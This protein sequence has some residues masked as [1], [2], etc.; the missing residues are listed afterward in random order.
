[1]IDDKPVEVYKMVHEGKRSMC[2]IEAVEG[3]E[4]KVQVTKGAYS[5]T[6]YAAYLQLDGV[7]CVGT[8]F[9]SM[10]SEG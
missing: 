7:E 3:K 5:S 8:P 10:V 1:M 6:D 2:Y 4:F 9:L